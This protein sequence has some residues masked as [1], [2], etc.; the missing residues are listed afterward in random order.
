MYE[1]IRCERSVLQYLLHNLTCVKTI[2]Q[3]LWLRNCKVSLKT[4][5]LPVS[6]INTKNMNSY[7]EFDLIVKAKDEEEIL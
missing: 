7:F 5:V 2:L 4:Q 1:Y 3:Y 6:E